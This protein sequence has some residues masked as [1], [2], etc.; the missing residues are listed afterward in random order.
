MSAVLADSGPL[1]ALVDP[2][3]GMHGRA[4]E[5]LA[6]LNR[7]LTTIV[8]AA[9]ILMEAYTLILRRLGLATAQRWLSEIDAGTGVVLPLASD[10]AATIDKVRRYPDQAIT[11]F[12]AL[13]AVLS[14]RLDVPVWAYDRH[15]DLMESKVWRSSG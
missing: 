12:D 5:E 9:P 3:D 11:L 10:H 6:Q 4:S 2:S 1:Y 14:E 8:V 13:L 15:F 7:E